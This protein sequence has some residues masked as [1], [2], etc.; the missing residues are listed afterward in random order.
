MI[1]RIYVEDINRVQKKLQ[2]T[3]NELTNHRW[4]NADQRTDLDF[5]KLSAD[6]V[7]EFDRVIKGYADKGHKHYAPVYRKF[8][9]WRAL[10]NEADIGLKPIKKLDLLPA[11]IKAYFKDKPRKWVFHQEPDGTLCPYLITGIE[12][13]K[14]HYDGAGNYYPANVEFNCKGYRRGQ[15]EHER[16]VFFAKDI[17][18]PVPEILKN[19]GFMPETEAGVEAY[20]AELKRYL[21]LQGKIGLQ[22]E[23]YGGAKVVTENR[24]GWESSKMIPMVREGIP[25]KVVLDDM[26]ENDKD[27]NR[28]RVT[29]VFIVDTFWGEIP[30]RNGMA[31]LSYDEREDVE[32]EREPGRVELPVHPYLRVFDLD[33]HQWVTISSA[34][35]KDYGWDKSLIDK[36]VIPGSDKELIN[37][38]MNQ[39]GAQIEDI[40]KGKMSG[41][42]VLATGAPGIGK[43]LTAEVFSEMIEKPLY[44]VQCSQLGL[45]VDEIEKNLQQ[46]L[47]RA[48]RWG[49]I[50]LIDEADVYIRQRGDDI[51]QNAIVGVFLRL[52]E[53]YRGVLFMTSNMGESIDDAIISRA[54]AWVRYVKPDE[55][56]LAKIWQV[57]G[58][59]YG[60]RIS[61]KDAYLLVKRIPNITGRT[62]RNLLKLARM[63]MGDGEVT[64]KVIEQ[65][66]GYQQLS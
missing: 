17:D 25:T 27:S 35:L 66:S 36:L 41:V 34:H 64:V 49:A 4:K 43:T 45:N 60:V 58:T 44:S 40:V 14:A 65:V 9:A 11:S 2:S 19:A 61:D 63:L 15:Q 1:L 62:V 22:L 13:N 24:W 57:L 50:L 52:V 5:G 12:Y 16:A 3:N 30:N 48:S 8:L 20:L 46:I 37:L 7:E 38:L 51:H 18:R 31:A 28:R 21:E 53:Y 26:S 54:T 10:F 32:G 23:A 39:T 33:K 47:N 59:Q 42:I 29:D 56:M 55:A 6:E